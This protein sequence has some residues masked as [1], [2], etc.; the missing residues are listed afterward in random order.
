M[1]PEL[2]AFRYYRKNIDYYLSRLE[3]FWGD[4]QKLLEL[5]REI[6]EKFGADVRKFMDIKEISYNRS[7]ER[8][9]R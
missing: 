2:K 5:N 9:F 1:T 4:D 7:V 6:A 8:A 3:P